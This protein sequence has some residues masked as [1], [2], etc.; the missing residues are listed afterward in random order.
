MLLIAVAALLANLLDSCTRYGRLAYPVLRE[1]SRGFLLL[2]VPHPY[3]HCFSVTTTINE[4]P[5]ILNLSTFS[6]VPN[7][8][9]SG[10]CNC[11]NDQDSFLHVIKNVIYVSYDI[12]TK[13]FRQWHLPS[14]NS[15]LVHDVRFTYDD[16]K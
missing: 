11:G 15:Y 7:P 13:L 16:N 1:A 10:R 3:S 4:R 5:K 9:C 6:R 14:H 8:T 2:P 12:E